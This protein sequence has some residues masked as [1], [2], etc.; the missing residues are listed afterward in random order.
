M[1]NKKLIYNILLDII[2]NESFL[3]NIYL[4][5]NFLIGLAFLV[6]AFQ[7]TTQLRK[8]N[9]VILSRNHYLIITFFILT[10]LSFFVN[11]FLFIYSIS[12]LN[13]LVITFTAICSWV[14]VHFFSKNIAVIFGL[15][16]QSQINQIVSER[17][18]YVKKELEDIK[19]KSA[20]FENIINTTGDVITIMTKDLKYKYL[21]NG[22]AAVSPFDIINFI[23]KTPSEILGKHPHTI[24]FTNKL[25]LAVN[26]KET[27][28]YEINTYAE[29]VG[30]KHFSVTMSPIFDKEGNVESIIT[31]TKDIS[32]LKHTE[33]KYQNLLN[34]FDILSRKIEENNKK[35]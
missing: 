14:F 9:D 34:E 7:I 27:I 17:I 25:L 21:N 16:T 18:N 23:G 33:I 22:F 29:K 11:H 4:V 8:R 1:E 20:E 30:V 35:S 12:Y 28:H 3:S 26:T 15:K 2:K 6:L 32:L 10:S 19:H 31:I 24:M 13:V 5:C